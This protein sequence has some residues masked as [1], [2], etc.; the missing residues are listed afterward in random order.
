M[1]QEKELT[2][3]ESR[4]LNIFWASTIAYTMGAILSSTNALNIKLC[5]GIQ[6]LGVVGMIPSLLLLCKAKMDSAYLRVLFPLYIIW[7][8]VIIA[9]GQHLSLSYDYLKDFLFGFNSNG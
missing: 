9:K 7:F 2:K 1:Q 8:V 4:V 3:F 5:Q 6:A